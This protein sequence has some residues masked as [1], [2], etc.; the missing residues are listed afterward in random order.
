MFGGNGQEKDIYGQLSNF[1]YKFFSLNHVPFVAWQPQKKGISL[2]VKQIKDVKG[3]SCVDQLSSVQL[4][5]K[6]HNVAQNLP[7]GSRLGQFWEP[8]ATLGASAKVIRNPDGRLRPPLLKP[9]N[10]DQVSNNKKCPCI[11]LKNSFLMEALHAL[12]Q[13][14]AVEKDQNMDIS[15]FL[16]ETFLGPKTQQEVETYP[17]SGLIE[18]I[19]DIRDFQNGDTR[20]H[21]DFLAE[22][23]MGHVHIFRGCLLP[24]TNKPTFRL[25]SKHGEVRTGTQTDLQFQ[26]KQIFQFKLKFRSFSPTLQFQLKQILQFKLKFRSFSPTLTVGSNN[27]C[28]S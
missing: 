10:F 28:H 14:N 25:D 18:Q 23:Q 12:A 20:E 15:G 22:R 5:T 26:I 19:S 16:Q 7:V 11:F 21:K 27:S 24:Y 1:K 2:M 13:R 8:W 6:V 3:V 4:S 9:T 17:R